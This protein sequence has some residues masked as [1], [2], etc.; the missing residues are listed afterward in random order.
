MPPGL[1]MALS[2][3]GLKWARLRPGVVEPVEFGGPGA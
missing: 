1:E 3:F 2:L